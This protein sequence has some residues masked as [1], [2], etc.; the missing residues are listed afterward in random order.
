M[1]STSIGGMLWVVGAASPLD[2]YYYLGLVLLVIVLVFAIIKVRRVWEEIHEES[3]PDRPEE[4]VRSFE[5]AY[6]AGE[7]DEAEFA[8]VKAM[9][10]NGQGASASLPRPGTGESQGGRSG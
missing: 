2:R 9:I 5:E 1:L 3:S 8:R 6:R 4:L 10:E 7:L